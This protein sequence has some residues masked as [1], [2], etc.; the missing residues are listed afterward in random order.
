MKNIISLFLIIVFSTSS[1]YCND[2]FTKKEKEF[3]KNN[4]SIKVG[5]ER[6]WPPFDFVNDNI[7]KGLVNDY[8]KIIS[9]KTNLNIEYVTDTWSNLLQKAKNKEIDLLPVIAKTKERENFLL[10]TDKYLEIR[11][12]LFS[13]SINFNSLDDLKNKTLAIPKDYAYGTYIIKNYPKIKIYEVKNVLEALNAV[14]ENKAD[15]LISNPAVVNY[16]TKKHNIKDIVGNFNLD[17]NKNS[18]FMATTKENKTL[19]NIIN[20]VLRNITKEEKQNIYYKWVFSTS[21][22]I[23]INSTLSLTKEEKEFILNKKRVTI[24]NELDWIPYDYNE[25]GIAKGYII[26]YIKLL[27][28]KLGL[29]PVFVTDKWSNLE[30][31]VKNK[32]IDILPVLAKNQK[33]EEYLNFTTR[34]LTQ[35]LTIVTKVSKNEIINLDD[36]ANRKIGMIKKWNLTELIKKNYPSI[37]VIEFDSIDDILDAIKHNFIDATI[38]NELLAKYYINQKI[39][40]SDLKTVGVIEVNGFK[41]D[42]FIGVRKDLKI[43]QTLYNKALKNTTET[44]KLILKNKWHN[45][46]KGLILSDEEK[47][48]IQNNVINI[49]FTSN[50]RPFS[51]VKDN[52]PQ[53]LAY[54]YWNLISNKVNLKTNYIFEDKFTKSLDL[55]K[56]KKRDL[57]LLTSNTKEREEYSIFTNTIFKTP[58][59]IAT[60]KDENYIPDA[61]Y[62]EGKKV[63]VGK[64]YTAQKLL[65]EKYPKISFVETK[66]LK[67]ALEL[68]SENRV[69][70]VIDSM[71]ALS[72]QIK[73]FA[74]TNIK[75]SGSTK[76]VFNM[77]MMI[78]DDYTILRSIINKVLLNITEEDKKIIK[79][80]WIN[81][82][83]EENFNYSLIW[84]IVLGFTIVLIFVI[85]KNRQLL[86]YQEELNE[87]KTNLENSI[88]NFKLLLDVNIAGIVIINDNKIKY[89]NDELTNI[90][91]IDSKNDLLE[92]D[93]QILFENYTIEDLLIKTKNNESFELELTYNSKITIPVLVKVKDIV[94]DKKKS[95]II[96]II[97]LTDIKNK[98]ELLLQ[99]S[100]MASLGEMIGNI[101]HQWRQPLSTISTA[102][103]GVKIQKEFNSLTDEMLITSLD[104]I[105][106]TTQFLSQTINDFQNYI[107]DDK[108]K[109]LFYV[110]DSFEKVLSI[111]NASFINHH[112]EVKKDIENIEVY[113]YPNELNQVLLNIFAN[114]KDALKEKESIEKYI[115]IKTYKK[116]N[117]VYLEI[118][119][120]GGGI[121]KE[122]IEKVFEPYFTT[123][124]KSQGTG[125]GLYMT[126]KIITES[127]MG[128][129]KIENCK[130]KTFDNCTKV[131]ISLPID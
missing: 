7:H 52:Q 69:Y 94:Y 56:E 9:N 115:F 101:A 82:E 68:L 89:I 6:D 129:I 55:I 49:S 38:Q 112:I 58:I 130:Y 70:A 66:N 71:P 122:I 34:I 15:A 124:H 131:T 99:Q 46:S 53:G 113:G 41:K 64:N 39:Y 54:D 50:W 29:E 76:V 43:L 118:I 121:K 63:A 16:L 36:L 123:K 57:L 74:F 44:E 1:L 102:A 114:S 95:Y 19:N 2:I 31:K 97:D 28:N 67:E 120:N 111:L 104:T 109:V 127:M 20:K 108:K 62:L 86:Q 91:K 126:H 11:D 22:E 35:E 18:L 93:L 73:E 13:K 30:N 14:L 72:D 106:Q 80:K 88:K 125:L 81:L 105:T 10:F 85:Y 24:G 60:L 32:E 17:Y 103:S 21:K 77:K 119:D 47:E 51:Y 59:G 33:R 100:K 98:E 87:T 40:E 128:K 75:I 96:S 12:Y 110:N 107:K 84:K 48:F 78:R 8:L 90:L 117:N 5:I 37:K 45:S 23:N 42:L 61:S 79:N 65:E 83:Y 4:P 27:S 25:D 3:I 92:K 116:D 26:D